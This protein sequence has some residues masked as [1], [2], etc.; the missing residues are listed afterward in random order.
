MVAELEKLRIILEEE[1][2]QVPSLSSW[3]EA[4]GVEKKELQRHL[5]YGWHC[6]DELL[7]S[8]R[9][10]VLFIARNYWGLGV[11]FEDLIQ[12]SFSFSFSFVVYQFPLFFLPIVFK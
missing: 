12:V 7:R 2:G 9:S 11:A 3:A 10:L 4:A 6:R 8:T 5:H 1:A